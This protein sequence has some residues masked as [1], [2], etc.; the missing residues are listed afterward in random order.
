MVVI[1]F[2][3]AHDEILAAGAGEGITRLNSFLELSWPPKTV[4]LFVD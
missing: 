3:L 1:F 4:P 2:F